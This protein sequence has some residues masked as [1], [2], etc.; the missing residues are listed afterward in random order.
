MAISKVVRYWCLSEYTY[1][2]LTHASKTEDC[3]KNI[4]YTNPGIRFSS[5]Q[6]IGLD[7][8]T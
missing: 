1:Q 4:G 3:N 8:Y 7:R 6:S 2:I 5:T